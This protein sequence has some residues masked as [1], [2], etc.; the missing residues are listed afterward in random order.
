MPYR[1][2]GVP[3]LPPRHVLS[4]QS[5]VLTPL[6]LSLV[7]LYLL[8]RHHMCLRATEPAAVGVTQLAAEGA[9]WN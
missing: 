4:E 1:Q 9:I 3:D 6:T 5:R 2:N 7:A 8:I